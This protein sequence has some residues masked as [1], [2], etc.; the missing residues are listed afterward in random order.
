MFVGSAGLAA[1]ALRTA[2]REPLAGIFGLL[3]A[4][5]VLL[6]RWYSR[7]RAQRLLRSGDVDGV[8][9]RWSQ[10]LQRVPHA[11]TMGPLMTATAFAAYGWIDRAREVLSSA[12]KGP[13]WEAALEHR[14]FLDALLLTFEGDSSGALDRAARLSRLPVPATAP[15]LIE[16][17]KVLRAAVAA[18]AR[19]FAHDGH[20]GDR[21]LLIE[22]SDA[23]P[24]VHWAMRYG[25]AIMAVDAGD[26]GHASSLIAA[27]PSWPSESC[28]SRFHSEITG[29]IARRK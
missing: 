26:F 11:E 10:T 23:S 7:R 13:A 15:A 6:A 28:F 8:L 4:G 12:E 22:A 3:I 27:A 5:S 17:I 19:A 14:L 9:D 2:W 21:T 18:L 29:E 16:R 24:L 20:A 1:Y 25:A